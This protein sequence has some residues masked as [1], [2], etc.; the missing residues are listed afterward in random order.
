MHTEPYEQWSPFDPDWYKDAFDKHI[1]TADQIFNQNEII[2]AGYYLPDSDGSRSSVFRRDAVLNNSFNEKIL[3][4]TLSEIYL[5]NSHRLV[6]ANHDNVHFYQWHIRMED[7][8]LIPNTV[9]CQYVIPIDSFINQSDRDKFK[10]SQFYRKWI[11]VTDIMNNWDVFGWHCLL[12]INQ[13]I[14]SDYEFRIDDQQ[15]TVRFRYEQF[16]RDKNFSIDIYK[17]DTKAS[18]RVGI[19]RELVVNQWNWKL[20]VYYFT[21]DRLQNNTK[22]ILT[23]NR[24]RDPSLRFDGIDADIMGDNLEFVTVEDGMIDLTKISAFNKKLILSEES[25]WMWLGAFV[26][27]FLHEYPILLPVDIIYRPYQTEFIPVMAEGD[28][29]HHNVKTHIDINLVP[30]YQIFINLNDDEGEWN[31]GWKQLI[32]PIVLSDAFKA[33]Q[34]SPY[35]AIDDELSSLRALTVEAADVIEQFRLFMNAYTTD[36]KFLDRRF[37]QGR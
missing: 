33:N 4:E 17:F 21:D 7:V 32:R 2:E 25:A 27:R 22:M 11:S 28:S 10:L 34:S 30:G 35:T 3:K 13:R 15:A 1:S 12:F 18:C 8:E 5:N 24:L 37:V 26:P 20:P 29:E 23:F 16:W 31:D 19:T 6:A 9:L 14:Y 36:D